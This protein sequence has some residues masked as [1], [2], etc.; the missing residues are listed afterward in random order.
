VWLNQ[1]TASLYASGAGFGMS[2]DR[3]RS[4]VSSGEAAAMLQGPASKQA[5]SERESQA[6]TGL[7]VVS[8]IVAGLLRLL[9]GASIGRQREAGVDQVQCA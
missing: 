3:K 6:R 4:L 7:G 9:A 5:S 8:V 1:S 2:Q